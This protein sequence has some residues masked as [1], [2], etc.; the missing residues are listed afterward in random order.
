MC[1]WQECHRV[2]AVFFSLHP[3]RWYM[4]SVFPNTGDVTLVTWLRWCL[5][6]LST[7]RLMFISMIISKHFIVKYFVCKYLVSFAFYS[8]ILAST[9]IS[10]INESFTMIDGKWWYSNSIV[11]IHQLA[12]HFKETLS[13]LPNYLY[14]YGLVTTYVL[15]FCFNGSF[16]ITVIYCDAY[17]VSGLVSGIPSGSP[18]SFDFFLSFSEDFFTSDVTVYSRLILYHCFLSPRITVSQRSFESF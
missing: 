13:S 7:G 14:Q 17:V 2:D 9:V 6:D 4:I 15:L 11:Y 3:V 5:Q 8:L 10:L 16:P 18:V 1:F 12:F